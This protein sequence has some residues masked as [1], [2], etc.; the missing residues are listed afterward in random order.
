MEGQMAAAVTETERD[1]RSPGLVETYRSVWRHRRWRWLAGSTIVSLFGDMLYFVAMTVYLTDGPNPAAWLAAS[2]LARLVPYVVLGPIGGVI[3]DRVD[4]RVLMVGL[5]AARGGLFAVMAVAVA[6]DGPRWALVALL[7]L[8]ATAGAFYEPARGA[9]IPQ[10]VPESDLAAANAAESG[11]AQLS[12]FVGPALGALLM[13]VTDVSVVLAI[14]ALTFALQALMLMKLGRLV[15]LAAPAREGTGEPERASP[16]AT[17]W[18]EVKGGAAVTFGDR[19]MRGLVLVNFAATLAFGAETILYVLVASERLDLG[20]EGIGYLLAAQ[21]V[22]GLI[23]A[24]LSARVGNSSNAGRWLLLVAVLLGAP[25]IVVSLTESLALVVALAV[26]E[27]A[28]A[29]VFD[30]AAMTLVQRAVPESTMGRVLSVQDALITFGQALGSVGAP[31][32]VAAVGLSFGLQ[33]AGAVVLASVALFGTAVLALAVR[34]DAE[35]RRLAAAAAELAQIPVLASF[36][37]LD[38]ERLARA[39]SRL[40]VAAGT[41][42]IVAGEQPDDLYVVRSGQLRVEVAGGVPDGGAA[43]PD[44][45][46]GDVFGE[47][48]LLR[49]IPRTATVTAVTDTELTVIDGHVF[50]AVATPG[51]STEPLLTG[52]RTRLSRTHPHLVEVAA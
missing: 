3:A 22:G 41:D 7:A 38:I 12:W 34:T 47:I 45:G 20:A 4:R 18:R 14:D 11:L 2:V 51:A 32:A 9:A 43:P 16:L 50:V 40:S 23:A 28:A 48:G 35:R 46:P 42:V 39:G 19:G 13:L 5:A 15:P 26:I 21:G 31:V 6:L 1:D 49:G 37:A 30:V 44:L 29:V 52:L 36:E 17:M 24:P 33:V 10:L 25:M 27:G 8:N